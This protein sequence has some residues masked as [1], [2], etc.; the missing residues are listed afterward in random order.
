MNNAEEIFESIRIKGY[1]GINAYVTSPGMIEDSHLE[2]KEKSNP[3]NAN[4]SDDDQTNYS[5]ALSG[6]ANSDGGVLIWG[7]TCKKEN[8]MDMVS[9]KKPITT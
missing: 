3:K 2:F 9:E 5:K 6:F 8:D 7:I 1:E 4:L